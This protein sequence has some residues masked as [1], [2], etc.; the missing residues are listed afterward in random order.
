MMSSRKVETVKSLKSSLDK[1]LGSSCLIDEEERI[2]D[3][4]KSLHNFQ[5]DIVTL[6]ET[7]I[8]STL[9]ETRK[10]FVDSEIGLEAKKL[11]LKWKKDCSEDSPKSP[12]VETCR[13][14]SVVTETFSEEWDD[15]QFSR[16]SVVR[17]KVCV[18]F[19]FV[20][21]FLNLLC[22]KVMCLLAEALKL[23]CPDSNIAKFVAFE[24]ES[25]INNQYSA[26]ADAKSYLNKAK[27]LTFNFKN[28][29]VIINWHATRNIIMNSEL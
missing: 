7:D 10:K 9:K 15:E 16:L 14:Q 11:T 19:A 3:I 24:V 22:V 25:S 8:G 4:L 27:S 12:V 13:P 23:S 20:K 2:I 17:R 29:E 6:R 1:A 28:N 18:E 21:S 26:E 5:M